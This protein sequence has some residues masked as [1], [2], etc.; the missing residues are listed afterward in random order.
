M[1]DRGFS[2]F[3]SKVILGGFLLIT[4]TTFSLF[5]GSS[6]GSEGLV[7]RKGFSAWIQPILSFPFDLQVKDTQ[8]DITIRSSNLS[9]FPAGAEATVGRPA[10][11]PLILMSPLH[12]RVPV[13]LPSWPLMHFCHSQPLH[14]T[15]KGSFVLTSR[16]LL[17]K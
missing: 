11:L 12:K 15:L 4:S 16:I 1:L 2:S 13:W 17:I 5:S 14:A 10:T 6:H 9:A 7:P 8:S 3:L